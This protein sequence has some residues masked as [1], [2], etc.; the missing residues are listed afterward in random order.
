MR[1]LTAT[2]VRAN[3]KG[4]FLR[5]VISKRGFFVHVPTGCAQDPI[6]RRLLCR[7][8]HWDGPEGLA[9]ATIAACAAAAA[10]SCDAIGTSVTC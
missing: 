1:S 9:A 8:G 6:D 5:S 3:F 4:P 7:C 10:T 2:W